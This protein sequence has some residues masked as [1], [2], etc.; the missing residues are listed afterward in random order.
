MR[1]GGED[2]LR[3]DLRRSTPPLGVNSNLIGILNISLLGK[4]PV[5]GPG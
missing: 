2:A 4:S 1:G 3:P 5:M